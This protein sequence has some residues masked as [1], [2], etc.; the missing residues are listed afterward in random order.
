VNQKP[1]NFNS[2]SKLSTHRIRNNSGNHHHQRK[3]L[4]WRSCPTTQPKFRWSSQLNSEGLFE[5]TF[6]WFD[7]RNAILLPRRTDLTLYPF[8]QPSKKRIREIWATMK[9]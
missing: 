4:K 8:S 2:F 5:V 7:W 9:K 1:F 6:F 3:S